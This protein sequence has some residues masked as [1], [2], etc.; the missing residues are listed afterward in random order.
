MDEETFAED[1][2]K[3]SAGFD[4]IMGH[5]QDILLSRYYLR[6]ILIF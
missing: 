5:L 6:F 1:R 3:E 4:E 2:S